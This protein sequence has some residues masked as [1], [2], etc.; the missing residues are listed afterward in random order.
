MDKVMTEGNSGGLA[1]APF[2]VLGVGNI[3]MADE[4]IGVRVLEALKNELMPDCVELIDA[5]TALVEL[6]PLLSKR[7]KVVV[8]DAVRCGRE[9]GTVYR[10]TPADIAEL[11]QPQISIHQIGILEALRMAELGG[12]KPREVVIFGIEPAK[13]DWG[14]ELSAE[15]AASLQKV[16][17]LVIEEI[18]RTAASTVAQ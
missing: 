2:L 3:L 13:V 10:F 15:V 6:L 12:W 1:P 9:P 17:R 8:I 7:E 5:G 16:V 14:M 11:K 4:G 18:A